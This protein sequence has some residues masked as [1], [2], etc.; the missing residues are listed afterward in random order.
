MHRTT[1]IQLDDS[2]VPQLLNL[3]ARDLE[4]EKISPRSPGTKKSNLLKRH[5]TLNF[6]K[7]SPWS[8]Y[9]KQVDVSSKA[10]RH[11]FM[12][13]QKRSNGNVRVHVKT[14]TEH[15][16]EATASRLLLLQS[17]PIPFVL[18]LEVYE[19]PSSVYLVYELVEHS[20][21]DLVRSQHSPRSKS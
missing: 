13:A 8:V 9:E 4:Q 14:I 19:Q 7:Q 5:Y 17:A 15:T 16:K 11:S 1:V 20:L 6:I 2:A 10:P 12:V 3:P 21:Q 18:I